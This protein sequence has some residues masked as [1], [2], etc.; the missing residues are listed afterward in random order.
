MSTEL[1]S[2]KM[3]LSHLLQL[4]TD[5][6]KYVQHTFRVLP[7]LQSTVHIHTNVAILLRVCCVQVIKDINV[8]LE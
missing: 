3:H 2:K 8:S 4:I 7:L 1:V 5:Y 6:N